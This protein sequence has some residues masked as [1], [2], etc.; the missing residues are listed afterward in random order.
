MGECRLKWNATLQGRDGPTF[1]PPKYPPAFVHLTLFLTVFIPL[2][3]F[4]YTRLINNFLNT[5]YI[6]TQRLPVAAAS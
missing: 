6:Y 3:A 5:Y 1:D 2:F 4:V